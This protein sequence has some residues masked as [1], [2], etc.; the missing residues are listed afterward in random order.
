M[1]E[2]PERKRAADVAGARMQPTVEAE[3]PITRIE[4]DEQSPDGRRRY[5]GTFQFKVPTL[6]DRAD[7]AALK[8]RYLQQLSNVGDEGTAVAEMLS[9]LGVTIDVESAPEWWKKSKL[10]TDLYDY[11]PVVALYGR[12]RQ[13]EATFLGPRTESRSDEGAV[14]ERPDVAPSSNVGESVQDPPKRREVLATVG[15]RGHG[16]DHARARTGGSDGGISDARD[17]DSSG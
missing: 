7:I 16:A 6:G 12:C 11:S 5:K 10:G 3:S 15:A 2:I 14:A 9:Y 1:P 13:Y 8:A 17:N 4:I